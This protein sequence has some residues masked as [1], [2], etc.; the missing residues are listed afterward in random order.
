MWGTVLLLIPEQSNEDKGELNIDLSLVYTFSY[1]PSK[2]ETDDTD[3]K[4]IMIKNGSLSQGLSKKCFWRCF[5]KWS[6]MNWLRGH[7]NQ[8]EYSNGKLVIVF[9]LWVHDSALPFLSLFTVLD[10]ILNQQYLAH[11]AYSV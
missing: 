9:G 1:Q 2:Q 8:Q 11:A 7:I 10:M 6:Y 5:W 4:K 3:K